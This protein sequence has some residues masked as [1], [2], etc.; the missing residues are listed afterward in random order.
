MSTMISEGENT[1]PS[2]GDVSVCFNCACVL[3]FRKDLQQEKMPEDE[4][5]ALTTEDR[6][7]VSKLVAAVKRM[8][9]FGQRH[10]K[11]VRH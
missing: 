6:N 8:P 9:E 4:L 2:E 3:I 1:A 10:K 7:T 11:V 5:E